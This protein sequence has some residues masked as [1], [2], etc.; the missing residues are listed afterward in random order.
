M[1]GDAGGIAPEVVGIGAAG[2]N[3]D[4]LVGVATEVLGTARASCCVEVG[5]IVCLLVAVRAISVVSAAVTKMSIKIVSNIFIPSDFLQNG[6]ESLVNDTYLV[7]LKFVTS[8]HESHRP[9]PCEH[10]PSSAYPYDEEEVQFYNSSY[11]NSLDDYSWKPEYN[12]NPLYEWISENE[13]LWFNHKS[14]DDYS[15]KPE[16]DYNPLYEFHC[17]EKDAWFSHNSHHL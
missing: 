2:A 15:W 9:R 4:V 12:Y 16:Y 5:K 11:Q 8:C 14:F 3:L 17:V 6:D 1:I 10:T 7:K 13:D